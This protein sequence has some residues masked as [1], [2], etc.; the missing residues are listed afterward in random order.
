MSVA[1]VKA[2]F[3]SLLGRLENLGPGSTAAAGRRREVLDLERRWRNER[4]AHAVSLRHRRNI[5][6]RG[7]AFL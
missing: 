3:S 2:Q 1:A 5:V 4:L 6:R 7:F